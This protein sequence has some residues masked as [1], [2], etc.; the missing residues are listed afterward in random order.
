ME[1]TKRVDGSTAYLV[2]KGKLSVSTSPDLEAEISSLP[3]DVKNFDFDL[4]GLEYISSAGLRV[5]VSKQKI[6]IERG[7]TMVI[8]NPTD[9]V[10]DIF[11][12]T[13]LS[14][15]FTIER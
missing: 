11:D 2:V 6:A 3:E 15:V 14:D 10:A 12:M 7:G 13:G 9:E 4:S 1:V 5:L 8:H